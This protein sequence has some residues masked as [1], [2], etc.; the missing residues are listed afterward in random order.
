[1]F[2]IT[3]RDVWKF[4]SRKYRTFLQQIATALLQ[5]VFSNMASDQGIP[6]VFMHLAIGACA[7]VFL[8]NTCHDSKKYNQSQLGKEKST[9]LHNLFGGHTTFF[10][11]V[12]L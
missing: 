6:G 12:L 4:F 9:L 2:F 5:K 8:Y 7:L 10:P 1:M 11:V 3:L